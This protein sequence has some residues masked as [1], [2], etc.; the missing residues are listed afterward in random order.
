MMTEGH[1]LSS[2]FSPRGRR[3]TR[4]AWTEEGDGSAIE[5]VEVDPSPALRAPSPTRG[6]GWSVG[7][8]R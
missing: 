2:T 6:E 1:F 8:E 4:V 7:V 5:G 3:W